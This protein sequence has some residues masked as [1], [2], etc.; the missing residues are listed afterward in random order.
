MKDEPFSI[1][2]KKDWV[3]Y[4]NESQGYKENNKEF[5]KIDWL[6]NKGQAEIHIMDL[7]GEDL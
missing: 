2:S 3:N 6:H 4:Y 1:L 5:T 7:A